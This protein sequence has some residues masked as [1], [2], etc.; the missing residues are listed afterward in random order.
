M[1]HEGKAPSLFKTINMLSYSSAYSGWKI[2]PYFSK[3][4]TKFFVFFKYR[5]NFTFPLW[6]KIRVSFLSLSTGG[7]FCFFSWEKRKSLNFLENEKK[8]SPSSWILKI[9]FGAS[10]KKISRSSIKPILGFLLIW[11]FFSRRLTFFF[12]C[13]KR[14]KLFLF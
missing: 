9:L 8:I 2:P 13:D 12:Y 4:R 3:K 10:K 11:D 14:R 6:W 5:I 1:V 7:Q